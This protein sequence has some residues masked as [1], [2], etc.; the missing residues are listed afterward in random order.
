MSSYGSLGKEEDTAG[1]NMVEGGVA[2]MGQEHHAFQGQNQ[3]IMS[4]GGISSN[5]G[6]ATMNES[7]FQMRFMNPSPFNYLSSRQHTTL[8]GKR[9]NPFRHERGFSQFKRDAVLSP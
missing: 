6:S 7:S 3:E 5:V 8:L 4:G 2:I 1:F 9:A